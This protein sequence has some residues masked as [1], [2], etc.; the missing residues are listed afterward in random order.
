MFKVF[1]VT[2]THSKTSL[3]TWHEHHSTRLEKNLENVRKLL[4]QACVFC[5]RGTIGMQ[6]S[7]V[8]ARALS[9]FACIQL[10]SFAQCVRS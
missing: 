5:A 8:A 1:I 7:I 6:V 4:F 9:L 3:K 10:K 2:K